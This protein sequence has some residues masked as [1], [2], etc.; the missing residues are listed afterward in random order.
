MNTM[1][2]NK[3]S[4]S[5]DETS[6]QRPNKKKNTP[7]LTAVEKQIK[8]YVEKFRDK[9]SISQTNINIITS[10]IEEYLQSF[11]LI[12]YNYDGELLT[13]VSSKNQ[14]QNDALNTGL[15]R[16]LLS[17]ARGAFPTPPDIVER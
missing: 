3:K 8:E 13:H 12:G 17:N 5:D 15:H 11:V 16:F 14:F 6:S 7:D 1:T 10:V 4:Q 2:S 9:K